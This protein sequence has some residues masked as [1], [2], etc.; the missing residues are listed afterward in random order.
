[1]KNSFVTIKKE[2]FSVKEPRIVKKMIEVET[3]EMVEVT[4]EK[5]KVVL[6]LTPEESVIFCSLI[7][8]V[9]LWDDKKQ[10][11]IHNDIFENVYNGLYEKIPFRNVLFYF[12]EAKSGRYTCPEFRIDMEKVKEHAEKIKNGK[13]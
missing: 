11:Y 8:S 6:E 5:T 4:K 2:K 13:S 10:T 3:T 9:L 7:G 1:M 12:S